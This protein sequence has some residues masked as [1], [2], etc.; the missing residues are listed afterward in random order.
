MGRAL[1]PPEFCQIEVTPDAP[2]AML[3]P[4]ER[5]MGRCAL[6]LVRYLCAQQNEFLETYSRITKK[7]CE[8]VA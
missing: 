8:H 6:G 4:S 3:L 2:L 7:R 1:V 5:G